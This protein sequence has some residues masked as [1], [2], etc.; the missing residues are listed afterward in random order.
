MGQDAPPGV[1]WSA[2]LFP[3]FVLGLNL[4]L[5]SHRGTSHNPTNLGW[6]L[7]LGL[8]TIVT[9]GWLT[10]VLWTRTQCRVVEAESS[11]SRAE[12]A[13]VEDPEPEGALATAPPGAG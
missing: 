3:L 11:D 10:T 2:H 9:T 1:P 12:T 6:G 8:G 5:Q 13:P 4:W 7:I